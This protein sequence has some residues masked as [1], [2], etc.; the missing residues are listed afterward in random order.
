M[1]VKKYYCTEFIPAFC[2]ESPAA[3][4]IGEPVTEKWSYDPKNNKCR[5]VFR[6][7]NTEIRNYFDTEEACLKTCQPE[8]LQVTK[9]W[10]MVNGRCLCR[11]PNCSM[12]KV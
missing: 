7:D 11:C 5:K 2:N 4:Y 3:I 8:K 9:D 1:V 12:N 6:G 10:I